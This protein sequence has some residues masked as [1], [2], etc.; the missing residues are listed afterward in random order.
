MDAFWIVTPDSPS[1]PAMVLLP[2]SGIRFFSAPDLW[3]A[4][5]GNYGCAVCDHRKGL[6]PVGYKAAAMGVLHRFQDTSVLGCVQMPGPNDRGTFCASHSGKI[7]EPRINISPS[8]LTNRF[9]II[10]IHSAAAQPRWPSPM[11]PPPVKGL[12]ASGQWPL[13]GCQ[14]RHGGDQIPVSSILA[15]QKGLGHGQR[16]VDVDS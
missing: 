6:D 1:H 13:G 12:M 7:P 10:M 5:P 14:I 2:L 4:D 9:R 8:F 15:A 3:M 11:H 16:Q